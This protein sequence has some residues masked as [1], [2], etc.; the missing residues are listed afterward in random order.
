MNNLPP[1]K[2]G[3]IIHETNPNEDF[4]PW[5]IFESFS[6]EG[7]GN[8]VWAYWG[9]TK[10]N[11]ISMYKEKKHTRLMHTPFYETIKKVGTLN[12]INNWKEI[13]Q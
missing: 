4:L 1:W 11:A 8:E 10:E 12:K 7:N 2:E 9:D 6:D 5:G 3:D 13:I